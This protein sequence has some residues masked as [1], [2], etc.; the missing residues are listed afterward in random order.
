MSFLLDNVQH[1]KDQYWDIC[2]EMK[3][4][5]TTLIFILQKLLCDFTII[6]F[7]LKH[8]SMCG[9]IRD[10]TRKSPGKLNKPR[11]VSFLNFQVSFPSRSMSIH[12]I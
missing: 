11:Q 12:H 1:Q 5:Q 7:F 3:V 10:M 6:Y 2:C 4:L 9:R 8:G